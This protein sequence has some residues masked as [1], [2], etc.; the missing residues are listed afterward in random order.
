MWGNHHQAAVA[1]GAG[2]GLGASQ[3]PRPR[4]WMMPCGPTAFLWPPGPII[5]SDSFLVTS[6]IPSGSQEC[7]LMCRFSIEGSLLSPRVTPGLSKTPLY[8][9]FMAEGDEWGQ[10]R[11]G[12]QGQCSL[13]DTMPHTLKYSLPSSPTH[14]SHPPSPQLRPQNHPNPQRHGPKGTQ[15]QLLGQ[16]GLLVSGR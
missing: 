13:I 14:M 10:A 15:T 9:C 16:A 7:G 4:C 12:T 1:L 5:C 3:R 11:L 6:S 8:P 2:T